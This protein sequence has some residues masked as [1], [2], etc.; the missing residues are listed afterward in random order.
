MSDY[1]FYNQKTSTS[2]VIFSITLDIKT[3][4]P[5]KYSNDL[6]VMCM[7]ESETIDHFVSCEKYE[8]TISIDWEKI[9]NENME[10]QIAIG[11]YIEK[12]HKRRQELIDPKKAGQASEPGSTAPE[13]L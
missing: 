2:K 5:W 11:R 1:L 8:E 10:E 7:K 13:T 3:W 4:N 9:S 12:R 6:C